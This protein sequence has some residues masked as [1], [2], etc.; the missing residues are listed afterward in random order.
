MSRDLTAPIKIEIAKPE[1]EPVVFVMMDFDEPMYLWSG[2]GT[3]NWDN[4]M[5]AGTGHLGSVSPVKETKSTQAESMSFQMT[6]INS[7]DLHLAMTENYQGRTVTM[8]LGFISE[9]AVINDPIQTF[10]GRMDVME[11]KEQGE[12]ST[13]IINAESRLADLL[14]S[15]EWRYTNED[16]QI[17]YPGDKGLEFI[18]SLQDKEILWGP[19]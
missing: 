12:T 15:R 9:G 4:H 5:W 2:Y 6:G 16:Q 14:K 18:I 3:I 17:K 8:W 7:G 11:I 19:H 10:S 13:I 1:V